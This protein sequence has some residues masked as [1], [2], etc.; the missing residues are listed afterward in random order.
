MVQT[1][2]LGLA[3]LAAAQ[4][5]KHVTHNDALASLD[6]LVQASVLASDVATPPHHTQ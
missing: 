5:Q 1:P 6:G 2:R 4:A 3:L